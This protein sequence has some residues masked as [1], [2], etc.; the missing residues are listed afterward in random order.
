MGIASLL[1]TYTQEEGMENLTEK[2]LAFQRSR[3][4]LRE[5]VTELSPRIYCYP[6]RKLGWDEDACGDFYLFFQPRLVRLLS[7]FKDQG[8]PFE[9]YLCSVLSWQLKNF[10]RERRRSARGMNISLRLMEEAPETGPVGIDP[11]PDPW[12]FRLV[13]L[14]ENG[15]DRRNL[16]LLGLK[17]ARFLTE[18]RIG[19]LSVLC[20]VSREGLSRHV[21]ALKTRIEP[22]LSRLEDFC[23][24]RNRAYSQIMLLESELAEE[25]DPAR[26]AVLIGRLGKMDGRMKAAMAR[27]SRIMLNPSNREIAL[28]LGLPK[29]TVDSGLYWLKRKLRSVYDPGSLQSA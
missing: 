17:C 2:V 5:L 20:G 14:I 29:G 22:R 27:M 8:K 1:L 10:A 4:G 12:D 28:E 18:E 24:R 3:S 21:E 7:R 19:G 15:A 13:G 6:R 9:S 23:G 11:P 26:R 16:L 25:I